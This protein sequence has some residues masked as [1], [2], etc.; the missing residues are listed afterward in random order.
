MTTDIRQ[1]IINAEIKLNNVFLVLEEQGY[2]INVKK[3]EK[4]NSLV[5]LDHIFKD[6]IPF[7]KDKKDNS[8]IL[9]NTIMN[10]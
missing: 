10:S 8:I 9:F 3:K 7:N 2:I 1:N 6:L 4:L 5:I